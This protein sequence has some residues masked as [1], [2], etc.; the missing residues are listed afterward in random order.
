[1][2]AKLKS[3]LKTSVAYLDKEIKIKLLRFL[4]S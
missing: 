4:R 3:T 1:M 2:L